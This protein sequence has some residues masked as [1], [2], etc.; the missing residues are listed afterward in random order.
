MIVGHGRGVALG[1][2]PFDTSPRTG[3]TERAKVVSYLHGLADQYTRDGENF[4][5]RDAREVY[6]CHATILR[7]AAISLQ[8]GEHWTNAPK[9]TVSA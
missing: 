7:Q 3:A 6:E 9:R 2:V 8:N 4:L 1:G 5:S